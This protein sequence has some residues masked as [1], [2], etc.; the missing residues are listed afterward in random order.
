MLLSS[1]VPKNDHECYV[2][3][4]TDTLNKHP[5]TALTDP[6]WS[7]KSKI[8][9]TSNQL[10]IEMKIFSQAGTNIISWSLAF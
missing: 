2:L 6:Q 9:T 1:T 10:K 4:V 7:A 3:M 5:L 8:Q